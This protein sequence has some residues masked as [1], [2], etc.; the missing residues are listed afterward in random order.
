VNIAIDA[1]KSASHPHH[2][3][4]ITKQGVVAIVSTCGN[5]DTHVILRGG[6]K[7]PN[8]SAQSI[9]D[10]KAA[11]LKAKLKPSIM[12]D[13]S[14]GNSQ[15]N[16]NNQPKVL[17]DLC[18]QIR[19]GDESIT[20][21]MLESHLYEGRQDVPE[22]G[23]SE[24]KYGVSITDACINWQD[25]V[26]SLT[27]LANVG[28][29]HVLTLGGKGKKSRITKWLLTYLHRLDKSSSLAPIYSLISQPLSIIL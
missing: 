23:P 21:I 8:Y 15:K 2:F 16:H 25:T 29:F 22:G 7:G 19:M 27:Q 12:V 6:S 13:C 9:A 4:S 18:S 24:L 10:V 3:L 17:Q 26:E 28:L 1:I 11:L 5:Q 14:H 20:G